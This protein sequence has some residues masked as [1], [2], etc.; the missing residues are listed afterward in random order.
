MLYVQREIYSSNRMGYEILFDRMTSGL[1]LLVHG[2]IM[3]LI[4]RGSFLPPAF[5]GWTILG[6]L[7]PRNVQGA[8]LTVI[9]IS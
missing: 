7:T 8:A 3:R 9:K 2:Y 5:V 4:V 1:P 6:L